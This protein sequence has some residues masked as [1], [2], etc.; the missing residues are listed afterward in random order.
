MIRVIIIDD[1][2]NAIDSLSWEIKTYCKNLKVIDTFTN[3][4]E[5]I[6]AINYLKPDCVFLDIEMPEMDGFQ[7]LKNL[8]FRD[9]ELIITTAYDNFAIEAFN[10]TAIGYLLKP[11][12][13]EDL[14]K[15]AKRVIK[16]KSTN[17]LG[18]EMKI[19]LN[20]L[21]ESRDKKSNIVTFPL[22]GKTI[23]VDSDNIILCKANGN[24]TLVH[25]INKK[26]YLITKKIKDVVT[27]LSTSNFVRVHNSYL[28]NINFV[29]EYI[30]NEGYYLVL[31]DNYSVP[32]S[33]ANRKY[34]SDTIENLNN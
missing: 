32:V 13:S 25:L 6:S 21:F 4:K 3:P 20:D 34:L 33:K 29:K 18:N 9:F 12:D 28:I 11:I 19:A 5:A 26:K 1:E 7:L 14:Q 2:R 30:K 16:I 31:Q 27:M 10:N 23:F 22:N 15:V 17:L 24:Y 8:M